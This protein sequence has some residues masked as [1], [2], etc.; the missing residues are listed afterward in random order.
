MPNLNTAKMK[1]AKL[2]DGELL[3]EQK[4]ME[5]KFLDDKDAYEEVTIPKALL[6]KVSNPYYWSLNGVVVGFE[7]GKPKR[8]PKAIAEHIKQIINEIQ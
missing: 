5:K 6:G 4:E 1:G 2:T 7:L 8:V 3:K